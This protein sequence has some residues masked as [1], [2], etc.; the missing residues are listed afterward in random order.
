ME[1]KRKKLMWNS[2]LLRIIAST[3]SSI[4]IERLIILCLVFIL[5]SFNS[6]GQNTQFPIDSLTGGI[7]YSDVV[8]VDS[9]SSNI[10]YLRAKEWFAHSF[11]SAQNVIQ[12][13][14]KET[15]KIIGK[16]LFK[17]NTITLGNHDA[18]NVKFTVE[19]LVKD[20]RYKY[21]ITDFWHDK[22][23]TTIVTP[24]DLTL[25]KPGGGI[26][27]MGMENWRA[28]KYQTNKNTLLL[29]N[30]LKKEMSKNDEKAGW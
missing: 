7:K 16:G 8:K 23:L 30:S 14:D 4:T 3:N 26:L 24:G 25:E 10:L 22:G 29:I 19:I 9:V 27:S 11:V 2:V 1:M 20:G 21:I 28:I 5:T 18:G 13:D 6:F 17:V 15:G 12:F